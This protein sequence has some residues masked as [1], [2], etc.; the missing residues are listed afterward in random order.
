MEERE[1]ESV[2]KMEVVT[3]DHH[4]V[5]YVWTGGRRFS[6]WLNLGD[7]ST[8]TLKNAALRSLHDLE[9]PEVPLE[10]VLVNR[11]ALLA[12]IPRDPPVVSQNGAQPQR[13]LEHVDK[14]PYGVVVSIPPLAVRG[15]MHV[16]RS[17]DLQRALISYPGT[18][19]PI[20][21]ARIVYTPNPVALWQGQVILINR[22]K[23][24]LYWPAPEDRRG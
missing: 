14:E 3:A 11:D 12:V 7:V 6:T 20:T 17:A 8:I 24:Q 16:A 22:D 21:E 18:F 15:Q 23:A 1:R 19:M 5:G 9:K 10:Y 4:L 2:T 13:P